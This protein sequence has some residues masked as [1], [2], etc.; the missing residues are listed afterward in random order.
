MKRLIVIVFIGFVFPCW[1]QQAEPLIF[2]EKTFDFGEIAEALGNADHEF[3]FTNNSGR[4]VSIISV[5]A[6]CGCTTPDWTR[7]P[8]P[9]GKTGFVKASFDPRGRPGYFNKSLTITTDLDANPIVL[10]VKGQVVQAD[11]GD[12]SDFTVSYGNLRFRT[13]TFSMGTAYINQPPTRRQFPV[14][15]AGLMAINFLSVT[16]PAYVT[17]EMPR[18]LAPQER[19]FI[20]VTFDARQ[21]NQFGFASDNIQ[22]TTDDAGNELLSISLFATLEEFYPTPTVEE[23]LKGPILLVR[24]QNIDLGRFR[25]T[26]SMDRIVYVVNAGKKDLQI[27]SIQG[28]CA[29]ISATAQNKV[30]KPGDSTRVTISFRPQT[31][32]G[33]QQK[34]IT[35]YSNDPR[36]PVQRILVQAYFGD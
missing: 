23:A 32:G 16:K 22:I 26:S 1:S 30:V 5:Q 20:T 10:Q 3:V 28:N 19:G 24:E 6:S 2:R 27:K 11:S 15:N 18:V 34:A 7:T 14:R 17:V 35:L 31:R 12:G 33:T 8:V 21:K 4:P 25:E 9:P 29:C 36:N 13:K